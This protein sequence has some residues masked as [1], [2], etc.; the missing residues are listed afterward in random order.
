MDF[1]KLNG[2]IPAIIQDAHTNRVLMLGFMNPEALWR[3]QERG[4]SHLFQP[5]QAQA[6]DQGGGEWKFPSCGGD[7]GGL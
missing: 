1:D 4:K 2:L 7:P 3:R 6:L 5:D